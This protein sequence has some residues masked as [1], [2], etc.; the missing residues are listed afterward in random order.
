MKYVQLYS[1][2][3]EAVTRQENRLK[4]GDI[5]AVELGIFQQQR[6]AI[7]TQ[8]KQIELEQSQSRLWLQML[9]NHPEPLA[10][11]LPLK[12]LLSVKNAL[13]L[14]KHPLLQVKQAEI[15]VVT[16]KIKNEKSRL[17]PSLSL[18]YANNSFKGNGPDERYYNRDTRFH[19]V[20][21]GIN[22]P[23]FTKAMNDVQVIKLE[24]RIAHL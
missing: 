11:S 7:F 2:Y 12:P 13:S 5:N 14:G 6:F 3:A 17:L 16:A 22:I 8:L 19:S 21:A 23:L 15:D 10:P 24:Q 4:Q 18:E 1:I 9:V 20:Q